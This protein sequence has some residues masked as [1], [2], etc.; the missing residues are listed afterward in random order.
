MLNQ[1]NYL[2]ESFNF[3]YNNY[4]KKFEYYEFLRDK[5]LDPDI[6]NISSFTQQGSKNIR[7]KFEILYEEIDSFE[8]NI[9]KKFVKIF[10]TFFQK[11]G[12][13]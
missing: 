11:I 10:M 9:R 8:G 13:S 3:C 1:Y 6:D 5:G 2:C 7:G 12:K 4:L